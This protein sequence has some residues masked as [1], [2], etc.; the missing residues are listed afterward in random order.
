MK[1]FGKFITCCILLILTLAGCGR[2]IR[3]IAD[4]DRLYLFEQEI[5]LGEQI[6]ARLRSE[7]LATLH[8]IFTQ[9]RVRDL[10]ISIEIDMSKKTIETAEFFPITIKPRTPDLPYDDSEILDG[11]VR[12]FSES[13]TSWEG[14]GFNPEGPAGVEGQVLPAYKDMSNLYGKVSQETRTENSEINQ[15]NTQ[16]ERSLGIVRITVSVNIDGIWRTMLDENRNPVINEFGGIE[17]VYIP[18]SQEDLR[19]IQTLIKNAIGFNAA[20]G[21]SVSVHSIPFDRRAQFAEED[22]E[23]FNRNTQR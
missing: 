22:A 13:A 9:D 11:I 7:L 5:R 3:N 17:R 14:T 23:Y 6:K 4:R 18:I 8:N 10:N 15:R 20:R 16:E 2:N 1:Q 21:D 12:S 19:E